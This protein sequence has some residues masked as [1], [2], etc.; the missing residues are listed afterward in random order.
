M[1]NEKRSDIKG[2][3]KLTRTFLDYGLSLFNFKTPSP[4]RNSR[5]LGEVRECSGQGFHRHARLAARPASVDLL[6]LCATR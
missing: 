4:R 2:L 1:R 3:D 5:T 6:A